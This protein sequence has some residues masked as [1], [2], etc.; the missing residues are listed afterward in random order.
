MPK[1]KRKEETP[2]NV[3]SIGDNPKFTPPKKKF[4]IPTPKGGMANTTLFMAVGND[5]QR[6]GIS[7]GDVLVYSSVFK[8]EDI[9]QGRICVLR[10]F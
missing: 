3:F 2:N 9:Y 10:L 6:N 1:P 5:L 7:D 8:E 4:V